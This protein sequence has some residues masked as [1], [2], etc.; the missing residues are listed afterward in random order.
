MRRRLLLVN[1]LYVTVGNCATTHRL[2]RGYIS[3][4]ANSSTAE[5]VGSVPMNSC[6]P[7]RCLMGLRDLIG[8]YEPSDRNTDDGYG[9]SRVL[10]VSY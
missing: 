9:A 4:H 10:G 1:V 3:S 8:F 6:P 2:R 5:V 7:E